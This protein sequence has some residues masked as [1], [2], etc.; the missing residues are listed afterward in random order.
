MYDWIKP[1][2]WNRYELWHLKL[3]VDAADA[4]SCIIPVIVLIVY[5]MVFDHMLLLIFS[6]GLQAKYVRQA[7]HL[8]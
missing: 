5:D 7:C 2:K 1:E 6:A 4:G 3:F 8:R